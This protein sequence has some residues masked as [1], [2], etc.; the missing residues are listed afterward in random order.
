MQETN[1]EPNCACVLSLHVLSALYG[2]HNSYV[3]SSLSITIR[4]CLWQKLRALGEP[5]MRRMSFEY[6]AV[7]SVV[8]PFLLI[9]KDIHPYFVCV[10][11]CCVVLYCGVVLCCFVS[12]RVVFCRVVLC[13][14]VSCCVV[15]C[16]VV[17]WYTVL[18]PAM[19]CCIVVRCYVMW[20]GVVLCCLL[21]YVLFYCIVQ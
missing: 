15:L 18:C 13:W 3:A 6:K 20:C 9:L 2:E 5:D 14:V 1:V 16:C 21:Y 4:F 7:H 17:L 19:L 10:L 8:V 11:S 12:C